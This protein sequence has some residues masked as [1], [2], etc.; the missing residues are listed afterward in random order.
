MLKADITM[1]AQRWGE[2]AKILLDLIG[3]PP[4]AGDLLT[5]EQAQWLV[6][7]A[8][9]LSLANDLQGLDRLAIDF[10]AGMAGTQQRDTFRVL[11]RPEK[12]GQ[13]RDI[14]AAQ[15]KIAEVDMFRGF[16]DTYR[17]NPTAKKDGGKKK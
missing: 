7:C 3:A 11:T 6:N 5:A 12:I 14:A 13:M 1:R 4:R 10:G 8:I 17:G 2:A 16:L 15:A 9:A